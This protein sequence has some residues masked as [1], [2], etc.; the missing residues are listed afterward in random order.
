MVHNENNI[1]KDTLP[2]P[3]QDHEMRQDFQDTNY[4]PFRRQNRRPQQVDEQFSKFM[5]VLQKL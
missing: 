3:V 4:L 2:Q 5:E 1:L